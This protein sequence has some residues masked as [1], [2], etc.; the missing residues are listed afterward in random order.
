[1]DVLTKAQAEL[2]DAAKSLVHYLELVASGAIVGPVDPQAKC[3]SATED[4]IRLVKLQATQ[5]AWFADATDAPSD[6]AAR[7]AGIRLD[8]VNGEVQV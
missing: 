5:A 8:L 7:I 4:A 1:M 6:D 3:I 2:L